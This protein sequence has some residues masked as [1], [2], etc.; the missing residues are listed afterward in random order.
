MRQVQLGSSYMLVGRDFK[1]QAS[2]LNSELLA[3]ACGFPLTS[4]LLIGMA[5]VKL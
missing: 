2:M 3:A 1:L 4:Q 5:A